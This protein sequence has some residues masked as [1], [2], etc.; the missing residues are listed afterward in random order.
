M[1]AVILAGGFGTRLAHVVSDVP[2]P[3]APIAGKPFLDYQ[4]ELLRANGFD[5][6][7]LLTGY[8]AEVIENYYADYADI[9]C[10]KENTPLGTG[11]AVINAY[12]F[13]EDEFFIVN[14]DTFF[15]IDFDIMRKFA[16]NKD[17]V[18]ALR[19]AKNIS[20]YGLVDIN[21]DFLIENFIEKG[22]LPSNRIDGYINGGIY[23]LKK[24]LLSEYHK[25][26]NPRSISLEN[27]IFPC[28]V[29]QEKLYGLPMGGAF[30]DIGIPEDYY[31]AQDYIPQTLKQEK[32]PFLFVDKD[33]TLI[34][35]T[36][37]PHGPKIQIIEHTIEILKGYKEKGFEFII[38]TNQA[39]LAKN[40]FSLSEMEE[41]LQAVLQYYHNEGI[42]FLDVAFCPYHSDSLIPEYRY[43]S[44]ARKPNPGMILEMCERHRIDMK[45]SVM[46]GDNTETDIIKLPYLKSFIIGENDV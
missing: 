5:N 6:F 43:L 24:E 13:L 28:L 20:R 11:G 9:R 38:V 31:K 42:D 29:E 33:G 34:V 2:K 4:I 35:N 12:P 41:N 40:K 45:N 37:Y 8:K 36:G 18:I 7:I 19:Y 39:G 17:A 44:L 27:E 22:K 15:D 14:G 16:E 30:I 1:Q 32:K 25:N 21:S 10:L 3:M 23:Y 46:L 26:F